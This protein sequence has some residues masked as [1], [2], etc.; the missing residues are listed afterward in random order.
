LIY[1]A[2]GWAYQGQRYELP[3]HP[4]TRDRMRFHLASEGWRANQPT[5]GINVGAGHVFANKMWPAPRIVEMIRRVREQLPR[6][7][8]VLLGGP[9]ERPT[10]NA[11][12]ARLRALD[13]PNGVIDSGTDHD[14]ASFVALVDACDVVF[15]GDTMA[16]HVAI[17]LGKSVVVF[18]GPTC[19]QEIEVFGNGRKLTAPVSCAPCYKRECDQGDICITAISTADAIEAIRQMLAKARSGEISP[20]VMPMRL[21][22]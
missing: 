16:M 21:A 17:A 3:L 5:L 19:E 8:V 22:G 15:S 12:L 7:Q 14:E 2:L 11:I 9:D 1:E 13:T 6:V 10:I 18:F 20:P 4:T